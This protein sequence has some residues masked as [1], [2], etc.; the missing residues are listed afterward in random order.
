MSIDKKCFIGNRAR[1]QEERALL[2][3][4][5]DVQEKIMRRLDDI[6]RK[7]SRIRAGKRQHVEDE[8]D[9]GFCR[10]TVQYANKEFSIMPPAGM[11]IP[12]ANGVHYDRSAVKYY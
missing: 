7:I 1:T 5:R 11:E 2:T 9:A 4:L 3:E 10:T 8:I 12:S 6:D